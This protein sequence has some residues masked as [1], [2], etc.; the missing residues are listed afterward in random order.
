MIGIEEAK[1]ALGRGEVVG[2]PT[3]TVY[4]IAADPYHRDALDR[5]F[6]LK[7]RPV[8]RPVALLV[9]GLE[10]VRRLAEVTPEAERLAAEHWPGGLTL[11]LVRRDDLP[12]WLGDR[13]R[14]TIGVRVPDHPAT[15]ALLEAAGPLCVSSANRSGEPAARSEEEAERIFGLEVAVYLPGRCPGGEAS[16]VLD[17]TVDPPAVLREGPVRP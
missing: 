3:D 1:T 16:T 14:G 7:G 4:G 17:L 13:T 10:Q 6:E 11:V 5:L 8:E 2:V 15:L 9:A 12:P